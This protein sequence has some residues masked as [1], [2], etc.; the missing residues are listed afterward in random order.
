MSRFAPQARGFLDQASLSAVARQQLGLVL[1][2]LSE[3]AFEG[4]GD[5]SVKRASRLAQQRAIGRVLHQGMLEQISRVRRHALPEQ[6]TGR[7]ETVERRSQ[8]RLRLA[9][10]RS[11]QGMGKLPPDRRADLRYLLGGAEPVE[12][13]HQR[14]VQACGNRQGRRRNSGGGL[15]RASP[16]LSASSTAFVISSTNRGMPSVRSMMSCRMFAGSTLLPTTR[17]DHGGDFALR[18]PI[19]GEGRDM[20]PSDPR[21]LELGP[22]RHDQ[23]HAEGS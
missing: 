1:G 20:R 9:H 13:R 6:Q 23:Q 19:E 14:G 21:R 16:S 11:Q 12:P 8:L 3:L 18:Q 5:A 2:N 22:E 17:V 4:F 7:N 10:H 15:A